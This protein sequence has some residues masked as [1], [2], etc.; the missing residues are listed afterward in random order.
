LIGLTGQY[1]AVD[2]DLTG[3]ENLLLIGRLLGH[4]GQVWIVGMDESSHGDVPIR[5]STTREQA[6]D[7]IRILGQSGDRR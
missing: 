1:A 3:T 5:A 4:P 7:R 6:D 2:E